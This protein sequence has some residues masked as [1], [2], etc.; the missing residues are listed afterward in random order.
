ML[1]ELSGKAITVIGDFTQQRRQVTLPEEFDRRPRAARKPHDTRSNLD[2]VLVWPTQTTVASISCRFLSAPHETFLGRKHQI[3]RLYG[4]GFDS[5][6]PLLSTTAGNSGS[7]TPHRRFPPD[8]AGRAPASTPAR[9]SQFSQEIRGRFL[10]TLFTYFLRACDFS[11]IVEHQLLPA[12]AI[13]RCR[14]ARASYRPSVAERRTTR[15]VQ[16]A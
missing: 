3:R 13:R 5:S 10:R 15:P 7:S 14:V 11:Q 6:I 2:R 16:S 4:V 12:Q 8:T 1:L 9:R